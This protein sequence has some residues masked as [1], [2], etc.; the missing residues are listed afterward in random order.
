MSR[1]T[2]PMLFF[3]F[4]ALF[5][6]LFTACGGST[7]ATP[8]A[9]SGPVNLT[10]WSWIPNMAKQVDLFNQTHPNIRV[11]LQNVGS[12][13][14]EYNKLYPA[15][16]ANNA[17][18]LAQ[19]EFQLLPTFETTGGLLDLSPYG[20]ASVK[21]Q[22]QGWTWSQVA[23]GSAIYAIPQDTGPMALFYRTDIFKKYNIAVPTT[24]AEYAAAAAKLHA[25][26]P[27]EYI[28]DFNPKQPGQLAGLM[29]QAGARWFQISGQ[30][31]KVG[32]NDAASQKVATYW[33]DLISKKLVKTEPDF[34]NGWYHDLQ[35]GAVATWLSGAWGAGILEQNAPQSSGKW[36][37]ALLPQWNA[38]DQAYGNWG[39][40][41]TVVF[42]NTQHAKEATEFAEWISGN[43]QSEEMEIS[44]GGTYPA[45]TSASASSPTLNNPQQFFG[46][47]N[48][49]EV[50][51]PT[52]AHVDTNF[53]W[54][55]T[56]DQV[57]NDMGDQ[58]ANAVNGKG[59]LNDALN[60]VQQ[61][62][63]T[64]MQKQGFTVAK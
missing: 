54:G 19:V 51:K 46:G 57:Y 2:R 32:I 18:D 64:F 16:K 49:N 31:W 38:G 44:G 8:P 17:P 35:T 45:L 25:A 13:P 39:G 24:W 40:S 20:A 34:D 61:S 27:K 62:T 53:L 28:T 42:K 5:A 15:I 26:D 37:V 47:Q 30:S 22:Y 14:A 50:L 10:Y 36:K 52:A 3:I 9:A 55:P 56:M 58:F 33:Q 63:L 59:T 29:W 60:A 43:P 23:Q 1:S 48:I 4:A 6:L 11:K 12:G 21:D 7:A 41:T